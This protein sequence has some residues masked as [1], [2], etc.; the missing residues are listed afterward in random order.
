MPRRQVSRA[1]RYCAAGRAS[2]NFRTFPHDLRPSGSMNRSVDTT[3]AGELG[4]GGI[5]DGI[6]LG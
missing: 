3:A 6:D 2:S 5:D 1:G 4:I